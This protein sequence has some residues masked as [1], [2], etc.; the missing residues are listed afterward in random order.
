MAM[1]HNRLVVFTGA[2]GALIV[3]T[4]LSAAMGFALPSLISRTYSKRT[5]AIAKLFFVTL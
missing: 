4:I 3:M 2:L 5:P 1:K